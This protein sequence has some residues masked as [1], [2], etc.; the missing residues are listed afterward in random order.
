[1]A[2]S[3]IWVYLFCK[4]KKGKKRSNPEWWYALLAQEFGL[5]DVEGFKGHGFLSLSLVF[6]LYLV[7]MS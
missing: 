2:E 3:L 6:L 5:G 4:K 1:M 7:E